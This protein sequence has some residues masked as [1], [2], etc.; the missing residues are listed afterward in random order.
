M[1]NRS[2]SVA[3]PKVGIAHSW[4]VVHRKVGGQAPL[5][6]GILQYVDH[7]ERENNKDLVESE[8]ASVPFLQ[9]VK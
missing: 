7:I 1:P 6:T 4:I 8:I 2:L 9:Q 5:G 3:L